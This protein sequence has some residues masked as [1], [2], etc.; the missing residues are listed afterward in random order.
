MKLYSSPTSPF[1][2]KVLVTMLEAGITGI[3]TQDVK[4]NPLVPGTIPV[5]R[6]PLGKVPALDL[7]DGSTIY[8]SR[9]ICRFLD[10]HAGAG[11]YPPAPVL[12]QTLTLEATADGVLDAAVLMVYE[13]RLRAEAL[14]HAPWVEAQWLKVTRALDTIENQWMAHLNAPLTAAQIATGCALGYLDFR[15]HARNW[16]TDRPMLAAWYDR[17]AARPSMAAT[18]PQE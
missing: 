3:E 8:D 11:L 17:F 2:R 5:D 10:D 6:N 4:G 15:L 7:D 9:V 12:W 18:V 14:R 16:R 1:V 13:Q